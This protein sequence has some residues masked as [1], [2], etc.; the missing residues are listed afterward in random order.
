MC[1]L[2]RGAGPPIIARMV[3][4]ISMKKM[5]MAAGAMAAFCLMLPA[6]AGQIP[7]NASPALTNWQAATSRFQ[8]AGALIGEDKYALAKA[9]LSAGTTNLTPPYRTMAFQFLTQLEAALQLSTNRNEPH[10]LQAL[11]E[12]CSDLRAHQ[13][14]LR[15]QTPP[16]SKT[17]S[18]DSADDALYAWRLL[19]SGDTKAALAE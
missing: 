2:L 10:R 6:Q 16:G 11:I 5:M 15:L 3:D 14:A 7:S 17:P 18:E 8:R 12:L 19:E 4:E 9:E 1:G 13:A